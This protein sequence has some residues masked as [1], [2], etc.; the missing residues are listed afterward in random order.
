MS[1]VTIPEPQCTDLMREAI[2]QA[3]KS[4][5]SQTV[6]EQDQHDCDEPEI[7]TVADERGR[8]GG[9]PSFK[10]PEESG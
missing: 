7:D 5:G 6:S 10:W 2:V 4:V 3:R 1:H 9:Y 8:S